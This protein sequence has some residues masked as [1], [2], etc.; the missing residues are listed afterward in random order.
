MVL[1]NQKNCY[2]TTHNRQTP[3]ALSLVYS[4]PKKCATPQNVSLSY[5]TQTTN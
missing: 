3:A 2:F 1:N 4:T 5:I